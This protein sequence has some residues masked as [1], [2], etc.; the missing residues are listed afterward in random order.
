MLSKVKTKNVGDVFFETH[1]TAYTEWAKKLDHFQRFITPA[2][3]PP[4]TSYNIKLWKQVTCVKSLDIKT[5]LWTVPCVYVSTTVQCPTH[6]TD[7]Q[8]D[9]QTDSRRSDVVGR[10]HSHFS[11]EGMHWSSHHHHHHH[12]H[13]HATTSDHV[14]AVTADFQACIEDETVLQIVQ[15]TLATTAALTL[16]SYVTFTAALT[17]NCCMST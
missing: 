3:G 11:T 7:R 14:I 12:H 16:A 4:W 13:Q 5:M 17:H 10:L 15:R 9:R 6:Q 1:C 8:T 2:H